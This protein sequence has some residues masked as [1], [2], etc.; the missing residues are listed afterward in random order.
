MKKLLQVF[1]IFQICFFNCNT[2]TIA[3]LIGYF[4]GGCPPGWTEY[5]P[6]KGR[7]PLGRD[8][9]Q[10]L[11]Q[12]N[13]GGSTSHTLSID[14]MPAH[15]HANGNFTKMAAAAT[16]K[17][18]PS[19][20]NSQDYISVPDT[21][22]FGTIKSE[23]GGKPH[24]IMPPYNVM[25]PCKKIDNEIVDY[26]K[27][28]DIESNYLTKVNESNYINK[29]TI[30]SQFAKK[31]E[32]TSTSELKNTYVTKVEG[33]SIYANKINLDA[34]TAKL[35]ELENKISVYEAR[36]VAS[37]A[38]N[39]QISSNINALNQTLIQVNQSTSNISQS[40]VNLQAFTTNSQTEL[41]SKFDEKESSIIFGL[42]AFFVMAAILGFLLIFFC[43]FCVS[44]KL[45]IS[46]KM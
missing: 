4:E 16:A 38:S 39:N 15:N 35:V 24:S 9:T 8:P 6:L 45:H 46:K 36:L 43:C 40:V 41:K 14:E 26:M 2:K 33:A 23:G 44:K 37:E 42:A 30:D 32:Y 5:V 27:K 13:Q 20:F 25:V 17:A 10:N 1:C 34:L 28:A 3:N 31:A 18:F 19:S 21:S 11:N 7:F 12:G 22:N 29:A